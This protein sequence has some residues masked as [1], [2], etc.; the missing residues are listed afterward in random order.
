MFRRKGGFTLIE[1]LVVISIIA[2]LIA[3][4]LPALGHAK[5][6]AENAICMSNQRQLVLAEA[7]FTGDH[8]GV[9]P[10]AHGNTN[11]AGVYENGW[12]EGSAWGQ[13]ARDGIRAGTLYEYM[14]DQDQAYL[15]PVGLDRLTKISSERGEPLL[16]NYS[17]NW[18]VGPRWIFGGDEETMDSIEIPRDFVILSEENDF[19]VPGFSRTP[20]NDGYLL[21]SSVDGPDAIGSFHN[22]SKSSDLS[23]GVG[24]AGLADGHVEAIDYQKGYAEFRKPTRGRRQ[25]GGARTSQ[26]LYSATKMWLTDSI[27]V[28]R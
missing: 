19:T 14:S 18:N 15:C 12:V 23:S 2:L 16:R 10:R 22:V 4:L 11:A 27:P 28:L 21:S 9:F 7:A 17:Q 8:D 5:E 20:L 24:F 25:R 26:E 3:L 1:L 6:S 13:S